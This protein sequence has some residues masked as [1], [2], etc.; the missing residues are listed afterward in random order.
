MANMEIDFHA[1]I[2]PCCD[3]G[4]D[5]VR[6]SVTQLKLAST[7]NINLVCATPH[8]YPDRDE[9]ED[10]LQRRCRCYDSLISE[11]RDEE[12]QI[13]LGA[14]V[15]FCEGMEKFEH[16][17][18]LCLQNSK[19]LLF[20]MPFYAWSSSLFETVENVC[21]KYRGKITPIL[22]HAD[23]Y[24]KEDVEKLLNYGVLLQLNVQNYS[25]KIRYSYLKD[26]VKKGYVVALGSDI[27]GTKD[28]YLYW[29]KAKRKSHEEWNQ[30]MQRTEK[31]LSY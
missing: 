18:S 22:A 25:K 14:E 23:R 11:F 19:L 12:P 26:W 17:E 6:T 4:S 8:F 31:I 13:L 28:G 30:I 3:H 5:S 16:L 9:L 29:N 2:L 21:I 20:E 24:C 27:H 15:L 7:A 1:H 10:F